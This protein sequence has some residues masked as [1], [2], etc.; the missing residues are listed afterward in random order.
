MSDVEN[1]SANQSELPDCQFNIRKEDG[2]LKK[3]H[4]NCNCEFATFGICNDSGCF[5]YN[6]GLGGALYA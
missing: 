6:P 4:C 3:C 5:G 1:K 2:S